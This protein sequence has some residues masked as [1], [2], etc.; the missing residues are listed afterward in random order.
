MIGR[1]VFGEGIDLT[2]METP[3]QKEYEQGEVFNK[4]VWRSWGE[5]GLAV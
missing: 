5:K 3:F 1:P 2:T 4:S